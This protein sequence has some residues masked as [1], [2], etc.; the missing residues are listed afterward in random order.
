MIICSGPGRPAIVELHLAASGPARILKPHRATN[1]LQRKLRR[2]LHYSP[3]RPVKRCIIRVQLSVSP[4]PTAAV[5]KAAPLREPGPFLEDVLLKIF[6]VRAFN[7]H[8]KPAVVLLL[9]LC[10]SGTFTQIAKISSSAAFH[11]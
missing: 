7:V 9:L 2:C 10:P 4:G 5:E 3:C 6:R 11:H 8:Q 1:L